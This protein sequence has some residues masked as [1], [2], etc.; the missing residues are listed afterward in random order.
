MKRHRILRTVWTQD[1]ADVAFLE[2]TRG[3]IVG[4]NA[5]CIGELFVSKRASGWTIDERGLVAELL[6]AMQDERRKRS[7]RNRDIGVL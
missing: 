3:K 4:R 1:A 5:D 7:F 6:G 2:A